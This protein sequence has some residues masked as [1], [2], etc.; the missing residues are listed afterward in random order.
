MIPFSTYF[1]GL[2]F[3]FAAKPISF[4]FGSRVCT[5][6]LLKCKLNLVLKFQVTLIVGSLFGIAASV[7]MIFGDD[8]AFKTY[9]IYAVSAFIGIGG[10]ALLISTLAL[11]SDLIGGNTHTGAFVFAAMVSIDCFSPAF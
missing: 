1:A 3:S 8:Y 11:T 5:L 2:I 6:K 7:W 10:T 9:H 4:R